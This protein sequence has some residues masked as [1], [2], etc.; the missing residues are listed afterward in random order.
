MCV[1]EER[2]GS[3]GCVN[4]CIPVCVGGGG[5]GRGVW[6]CSLLQFVAVV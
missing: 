3:N 4:V 1:G 5:G 6:V 2:V